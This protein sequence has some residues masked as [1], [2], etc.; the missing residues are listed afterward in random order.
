MRVPCGEIRPVCK[1]LVEHPNSKVFLEQRKEALASIHPPGR[2]TY[3]PGLLHHGR[4]GR[5]RLRHRGREMRRRVRP[6]E[7]GLTAQPTAQ[8]MWTKIQTAHLGG[9]PLQ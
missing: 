5:T 2:K 8:Q 7:Q 4:G 3:F 1:S 6:V 9:G